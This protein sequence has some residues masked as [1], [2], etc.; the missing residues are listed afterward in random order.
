MTTQ[1]IY[2]LPNCKLVVEG[3]TSE[4]EAETV[5]GRPLMSIVT[6]VECHFLE[7]EQPLTGGREFLESLAAAVS[8][9]AQEYLSGI[10]RMSDRHAAHAVQIHAIDKNHHRLSVQPQAADQTLSFPAPTQIDLNTVQLFDLVEAI[11]QFYADTQTLPDVSLKLTSLPKRQAVTQRE[12]V[13]K[14]ALP[15]AV[16][17]SGLAVAALAFFLVPVP[18]EVRRPQPSSSTPQESPIAAS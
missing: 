3:F 13:A 9:Y 14:Q 2:S 10:A 15:A 6:N 8:G 12:P 4:S 7:R 18:K 5:L 11:D 17:V 16:G 1:R